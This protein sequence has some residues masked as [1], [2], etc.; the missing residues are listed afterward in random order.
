MGGSLG[1]VEPV[2]LAAG[3]VAYQA[4]LLGEGKIGAADA[5]EEGGCG[6]RGVN[7]FQASGADGRS[8]G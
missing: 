6:S 5:D 8:I 4:L 3:E 2:E 1:E 7:H